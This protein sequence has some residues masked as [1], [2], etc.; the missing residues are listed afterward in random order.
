MQRRLKERLI[1][2]AV[3]VMLAVIFIPMLLNDTSQTESRITKTNIPAKPDTQF[4]SRMV[5]LGDAPAPDVQKSPDTRPPAETQPKPDTQQA[6]ATQKQPATRTTEP[7]P[8]APAPAPAPA[9]E[10]A[11]RSTDKKTV[12][13]SPKPKPA[14][15]KEDIGLTAWVVQLGSFSSEANANNLND[16]LHKAGYTSFVEPLKHDG[17][18]IYRVRVGPELLRSNAQKLKERLHEKMKL[19]GIILAYP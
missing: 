9:P 18:V 14:A 4:N 3:L 10:A 2:A 15:G 8:A 6:A 5:P 7:A 13:E 1:G 19:D 11:G 12:E 17:N 16:E